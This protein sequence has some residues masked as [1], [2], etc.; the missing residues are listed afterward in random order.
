[1][2]NGSAGKLTYLVGVLAAG[3]DCTLAYVAVESV[4]ERGGD[5]GACKLVSL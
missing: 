1:M 2:G 4:N 5:G 3:S